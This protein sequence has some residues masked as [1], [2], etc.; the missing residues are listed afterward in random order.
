MYTITVN[1]YKYN[2]FKWHEQVL[3][4][5]SIKNE[6]KQRVLRLQNIIM[7]LLDESTEFARQYFQNQ[8][9]RTFINQK[10]F[11]EAYKNV[12]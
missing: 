10:V 11:R 6:V 8:T 7:D 2:Q 3:Y 9:F 1:I 4:K 12:K 5:A